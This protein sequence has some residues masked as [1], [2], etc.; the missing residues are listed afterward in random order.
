[1]MA[2]YV[3]YTAL[4]ISLLSVNMSNMVRFRWLHL[5][6]SCIYCMYGVLIEAT[7]LIVGALMFASIHIYRLYKLYHVKV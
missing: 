7:P 1:M 4:A 3:G 5:S 2:E 6:S